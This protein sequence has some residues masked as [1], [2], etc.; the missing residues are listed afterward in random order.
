VFVNSYTATSD[1]P[2]RLSSS[3]LWLKDANIHVVT[4]SAKYGNAQSR[5]AT[6]SA[7]DIVSFQDFNLYDMFFEN[8]SAGDNTTIYIVG[9]TMSKP[10]IRKL[11]E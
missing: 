7:G 8:A 1:N 10:E 9:V 6:I 3:A 5:P 4:N 11:L 2:F